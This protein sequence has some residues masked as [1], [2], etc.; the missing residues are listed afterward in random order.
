MKKISTVFLN[1][2]RNN[3]HYEFMIVFK[4]LI[5]N[6]VVVQTIIAD[7]Y[8]TFVA[9]LAKEELLLDATQ[10]SVFTRQIADADKR[11]DNTVIGLRTAIN[12][13]LY[14]FE[15][16]KKLAAQILKNRIK[17]IKKITA[18]SYEDETGGIRKLIIDF[19]G[20][21]AGQIEMLG[22]TPWV[23]EL[24]AAETDF[25]QLMQL[26]NTE[27]LNKLPDSLKNVRAEI[28]ITYHNIVDLISAAAL[29]NGAGEYDEFIK[30]LNI[31]IKY[32]NEHAAHRKT[33][34]DINEIIAETVPP[35]KYTGKPVIVIP[36]LTDEDGNELVF[37]VDFSVK[38][39]KNTDIGNA[40]IIVSGKGNYKGVKEIGFD[41]VK[42]I[43]D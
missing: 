42:P 2:F 16:D 24:K 40:K 9:H 34:K 36:K 28:D 14:S 4:N 6:F 23:V 19:E 37:T 7:W 32:F 1:F 13:N 8:N 33:K 21:Y 12:S 3:A 27:R 26:R 17:T 35:Q 25:S 39:K 41:I 22:L 30:Q 20:D 29:V 10:K 5:L 11:V 38:Y 15:P 31:Q 18:N 43:D